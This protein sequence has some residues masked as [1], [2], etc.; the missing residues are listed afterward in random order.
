LFDEFFTLGQQAHLDARGSALLAEVH[1]ETALRRFSMVPARGVRQIGGVTAPF[2]HFGWWHL[3]VNLLFFYL[4]A[5]FLEDVWG[6]W[7]FT[8]V[9]LGGGALATL[10]QAALSWSSTDMIL[11]ASGAIA[12][13]MGAFVP[14]TLRRV[15]VDPA[16]ATGPF[17]TT[18]MDAV[19]VTVYLSIATALATL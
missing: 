4:V 18:T 6:Q 15:G 17:V 13:L 2:V 14:L 10:A 16:I 3:L 12:A 7:L 1:R 8:L 5:A 19:G 9:Y 11:G